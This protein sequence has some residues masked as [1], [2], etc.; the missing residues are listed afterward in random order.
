MNLL[1][2]GNGPSVSENAENFL[3]NY[4]SFSCSSNICLM[5]LITK[6]VRLL[7][8]FSFKSLTAVNLTTT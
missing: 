6:L 8:V 3:S 2:T 4:A 5:E 7:T 1:E